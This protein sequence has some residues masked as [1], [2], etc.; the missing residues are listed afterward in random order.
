MQVDPSPV[1]F[2]QNESHKEKEKELPLLCRYK[3]RIIFNKMYDVNQSE[4][5]PSMCW[6]PLIDR[7]LAA[8]GLAQVCHGEGGSMGRWATS[9]QHCQL[10][11]L[12]FSCMRSLC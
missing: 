4:M 7:E 8:L 3:L 2:T 12:D 10:S 9:T 5:K 11:P 6:L 1:M